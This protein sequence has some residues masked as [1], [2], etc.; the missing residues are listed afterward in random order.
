MPA[1]PAPGQKPLGE[2]TANFLFVTAIVILC[3]SFG[4]RYQKIEEVAAPVQRSGFK[5]PRLFGRQRAPKAVTPDAPTPVAPATAAPVVEE[6]A[7]TEHHAAPLEALSPVT[8][9]EVLGLLHRWIDGLNRIG[10]AKIRGENYR[11]IAAAFVDELYAYGICPV[12]FKPAK[13]GKRP[14]RPTR[15]GALSYFIGGNPAFPEDAGFAL[16]VWKKIRLGHTSVSPQTDGAVVMGE[17]IFTDQSK[18]E[19]KAEFTFGVRRDPEGLLRIV[20]HHSSLPFPGFAPANADRV[21]HAVTKQEVKSALKAWGDAIVNIGQDYTEHGQYAYTA[22]RAIDTLYGYDLYPVLFKPTEADDQNF[23]STRAGALSYF[24]GGNSDYPGDQGFA[25]R[26]SWKAVR[27]DKVDISLHESSAMAMGEYYFENM[28]GQELKAG[29]TIGYRHDDEG[30]LR[31]VLHQS[32]LP[33]GVKPDAGIA[34]HQDEV[35]AALQ[36]FGDGIVEIGATFS[37]NGDYRKKAGDVIDSL[38][39]YDVF[40]VLLKP[41]KAAQQPFRTTREG[42]LSYY[43]GGNEDFPEDHGFA[44]NPWVGVSFEDLRVSCQGSTATAMGTYRFADAAGEVTD[45]EF[46]IGYRRDQSGNLRI[47]LHHSSLPFKPGE[48]TGRSGQIKQSQVVQA[49]KNWGDSI[50]EIGEVY[51]AQGDYLE[52]GKAMINALYAYD[53]YPVLFKPAQASY[54]PFR[55][56]RDGAVSYFVGGDHHFPEDSGFALKPWKGVRLQP[57]SVSVHGNTAVAMGT[58]QFVDYDGHSMR[59]EFTF[60]YRLDDAG[61]MRIVLHHSSVPYRV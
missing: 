32:S 15:E 60:G 48:S 44:I 19:H 21:R 34:V 9:D 10:Q 51:R 27:F 50:I 3:A 4:T 61:R 41:T 47:V 59:A 45:A 5:L 39:A 42:A 25:T 30:K 38:Y 22:A 2:R 23:R 14:F 26:T 52:K 49:L 43:V 55:N 29:F 24:I 54:M 46:T 33:D 35:V 36:K 58:Y 8:K 56:T 17:Y 12:M 16:T 13:A 40:P 57:Q 31:I 1:R 20:L 7:P 11:A 6:P 37:S 53:V 18:K 28:H